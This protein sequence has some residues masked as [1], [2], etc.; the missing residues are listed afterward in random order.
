MMNKI[1]PYLETAVVVLAVLWIINAD[2]LGLG[3][4]EKLGI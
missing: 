3:I 2:P 1:K 4:K